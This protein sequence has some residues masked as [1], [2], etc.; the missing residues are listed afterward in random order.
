[1]AY[2]SN[3]D[4]LKEMSSVELA[5]L[6]GDPTG[7]WI[8]TLRTDHAR[9]SADLTID[10]YLVDSFAV[11]FEGLTDEIINKISNDLTIANLYDYA[12]RDSI[13]PFAVTERRAKAMELLVHIKE[14]KAR[15]KSPHNHELF[16]ET[17]YSN[18]D[19]SDK[20]F[21][22]DIFEQFL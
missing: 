22:E 1:M 16:E 8:D 18:K 21:G 12:Y 4:I 19:E 14:G 13:V 17:I 10:T 5:I 6:A 7:L 15:L 3:A 20:L 9:K 2:S 11:P